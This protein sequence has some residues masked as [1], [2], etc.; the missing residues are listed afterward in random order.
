MWDVGGCVGGCGAMRWRWRGAMGL[1][2]QKVW[3]AA[4]AAAAV[5]PVIT[6]T[7]GGGAAG[8]VARRQLQVRIAKRR[9]NAGGGGGKHSNTLHRNVTAPSFWCRL[10]AAAVKRLDSEGRM[11][12]GSAAN[13]KLCTRATASPLARVSWG[14]APRYLKSCW[15][16]W[17]PASVLPISS[18][19][20][21]THPGERSQPAASCLREC[22]CA[23]VIASAHPGH[24]P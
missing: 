10:Y 11:V 2:H 12:L 15:A 9:S 22:R 24:A 21:V 16:T 17:L 13:V 1:L 3:A 18:L 14:L 20:N 5:V 7:T 6:S 8:D 19:R 4:A 23:C